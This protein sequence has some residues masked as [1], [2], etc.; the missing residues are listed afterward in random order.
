VCGGGGGGQSDPRLDSPSGDDVM[1]VSVVILLL[2][3]FLWPGDR[4]HLLH[5]ADSLLQCQ[6]YRGSCQGGGEVVEGGGEGGRRRGRSRGTLVPREREE[7]ED[8]AQ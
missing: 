5:L 3:G 4:L 2:P 8:N 1:F 7:E 6:A